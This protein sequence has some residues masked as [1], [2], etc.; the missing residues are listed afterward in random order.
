MSA[1]VRP[2][3]RL[4]RLSRPISSP[5]EDDAERSAAL[6]REGLLVVQVGSAAP[7]RPWALAGL[8][9]AAASLSTSGWVLKFVA[10]PEDPR[11]SVT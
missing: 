9:H 4:S 8:G 5:Q 7:R 2:P 3:A 1:P 10:L 11:G 6:R